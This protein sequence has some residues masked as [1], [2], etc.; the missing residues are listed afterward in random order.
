MW[1]LVKDMSSSPV[2]CRGKEVPDQ[3][4]DVLQDAAALVEQIP[5]I[6]Y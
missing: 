2:L 5:E 6:A 3:A 1:R 4:R